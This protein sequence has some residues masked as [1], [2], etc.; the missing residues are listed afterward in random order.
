MLLAG[1]GSVIDSHAAVQ[2]V[3]FS[4]SFPIMANDTA[5]FSY[6]SNDL[7]MEK[8]SYNGDWEDDIQMQPFIR[9]VGQVAFVVYL[10]V[11]LFGIPANIYVLWR[12]FRLAKH[13]H[14]KYTNGT[15]VGLLSMSIADLLSLILIS[16]QNVLYAV[17]IDT[18]PSIKRVIC[19]VPFLCSFVRLCD[20][21]LTHPFI[22]F[23]LQTLLFSTHTATSVSIWSWLFMS[24]LRFLAVRYPIYHFR[25]WHTPYRAIAFII[26]FSAITNVWLLAAVDYDPSGK[27]FISSIKRII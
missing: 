12:M 2:F 15:G 18:S 10:F 16:L 25:L 14:E 19:K 20:N 13:D 3:P 4:Q 5:K 24:A 8:D 22:K 11:F 6:D 9:H 1:G 17:P 7:S 23:E 26:L 21:T 27:A